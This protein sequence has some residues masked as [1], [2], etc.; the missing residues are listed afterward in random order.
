[1]WTGCLEASGWGDEGPCRSHPAHGGAGWGGGLQIPSV[2]AQTPPS[3]SQG[4]ALFKLEPR[5]I[6]GVPKA[7]L[8]GSRVTTCPP[9]RILRVGGSLSYRKGVWVEKRG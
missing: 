3:D 5:I 1:M 4:P 7:R 8:F 6:S 2:Q 9:C